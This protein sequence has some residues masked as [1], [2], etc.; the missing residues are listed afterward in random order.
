MSLFEDMEKKSDKEIADKLAE[1]IKKYPLNE[2]IA[3]TV[4]ELNI[5][6]EV[7]NIKIESSSTQDDMCIS[8]DLDTDKSIMEKIKIGR[9][10]TDD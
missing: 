7:F 6:D 9:K 2:A 5:T 1:N 3:K 10:S 4:E 8:L